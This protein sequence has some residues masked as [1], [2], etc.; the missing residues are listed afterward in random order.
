MRILDR[1][2]VRQLAPVWL[3]CLVV[4]LFLSCFIDLFEHLDEILR[5]HI[6]VKTIWD[7]YLNFLPLV[8]VRACPL[9]LLLGASFVAT[10]LSRYQEFLAMNAS[11]TSLL[12]AS[13]PFLFVGWLVSLGVFFVNDTIVPKT[14]AAYE[15]IR[16][17][18][19]RGRDEK[20]TIDN[21]AIMDHVNRLYHARELNIE[22]GELRD[23]TVL[24]HDWGN[25]PIK[26]LYAS[27]AI[28]TKHGWLLL[29]GT[30]YRVG[31]RGNLKGEPEPFVERLIGYPV[32]VD[33]FTQPETRPENMR[34]GQLRQLILR[35]KQTG[36]G[37]GVRRY[38]VELI[39]KLTL[40]LMNLVVC[41][42]AFTGSTRPQLRG[43][44]KGLGTSLGWGLLYYFGVGFAE[45]VGKKGV[46]GLPVMV[47]VWLPHVVAVWCCVR[48][49][50]RAA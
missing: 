32:T 16:Q 25:R 27:R 2:A 48:V 37:S 30:I 47:A 3:W 40:P 21:V 13:V 45:G 31:P 20:N 43:N 6:P 46:F 23:L 14:S 42:I 4:F 36:M 9:A 11:G 35:L 17:D 24:E 38:R 39:S 7:Y 34:Y 44:L 41:L 22:E 26:N 1:Y 5:Y 10:R 33:S 8:F 49:L 18:A 15:R 29:H 12:R 28:W 19:F 50:K